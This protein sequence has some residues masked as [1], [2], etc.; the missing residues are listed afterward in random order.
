ML[1]DVQK[2]YEFPPLSYD[3]T[4]HQLMH[5]NLRI[6]EFKSEFSFQKFF[7][8]IFSFLPSTV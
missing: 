2:I 3:L 6:F 1:T 7:H 4:A 5:F 8:Y